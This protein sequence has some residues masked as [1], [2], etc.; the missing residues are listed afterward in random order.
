MSLLVCRGFQLLHSL[1]SAFRSPLVLFR[2]AVSYLDF[3]VLYSFLLVLNI[4]LYSF[5]THGHYCMILQIEGT[6]V[7]GTISFPVQEKYKQ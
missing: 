5:S 3:L 7:F 4:C 2:I 1:F 6:T